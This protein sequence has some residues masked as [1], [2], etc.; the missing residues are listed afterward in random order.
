MPR[1]ADQD[2]AARLFVGRALVKPFYGDT[3][4]KTV[5]RTAQ[6]ARSAYAGAGEA[7]WTRGIFSLIEARAAEP[8][9]GF[10]V[11]VASA[12]DTPPVVQF[13]KQALATIT[14]SAA[15]LCHSRNQPAIKPRQLATWPTGW[16]PAAVSRTPCQIRILGDRLGNRQGCTTNSGAI[17]GQYHPTL[18]PRVGIEP[19]TIR[20]TVECS[21]AELPRNS[22]GALL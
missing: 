16:T 6:K 3:A 22:V 1:N 19:T 15:T 13:V 10:S 21:T 12:G 9:R 4:A 20:L 2:R 5:V 18:A 17:T 14:P 7:A 8:T 11:H